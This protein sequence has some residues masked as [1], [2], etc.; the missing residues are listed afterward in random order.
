V[1]ADYDIVQAV[2]LGT[3]NCRAIA[4][5]TSLSQHSFGNAIDFFGFLDAQG[6]DFVVQRDF[7]VGVDNPVTEEGRLLYDIAHRM[8]DQR[9][10]NIILTPNYNDAHAD[11]FHVD[12]TAGS[13]FL[14]VREVEAQASRLVDD[15]W[16][17]CPPE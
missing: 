5:S 9:I 15:E 13:H 7:E 4:G 1:L 10:F 8:Y 17:R 16:W 11:H 2:H 12:L 3:F 14:G 6:R